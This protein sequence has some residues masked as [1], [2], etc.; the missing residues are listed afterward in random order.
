MNGKTILLAVDVAGRE[1]SEHVDSAT[2]ETLQL[3]QATGD[4]V[5]VLHVHEYAYG[6]FGKLQVDCME[7]AGEKEV[8]QIVSELRDAGVQADGEIG[9]ADFGHVARA[10]LKVA[11]ECDARM[12]VLGSSSRTDLPLL[13][14]GSVSTRLLHLAR[15][16]VL[17]VPWKKVVAHATTEELA[18][19]VAG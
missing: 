3:S 10:I 17:I 18:A 5:L 12:V 1:F 9:G 13:P 7:G 4:R 11:D 19:E 2:R 6:R 8:E 15:R 14:F 16:P